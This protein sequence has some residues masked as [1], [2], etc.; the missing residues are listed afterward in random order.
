MSDK[1]TT[2]YH[3]AIQMLMANW[4]ASW[5]TF[6]SMLTANIFIAA[7]SG[8]V[9]GFYPERMV[10][11]TALGVVGLGVCLCWLLVTMRHF[12]YSKY[13]FAWARHYEREYL[14][15]E[16]RLI[17]EGQKF[18]KGEIPDVPWKD[19]EDP[20]RL[21]AISRFRVEQLMIIVICGFILLYIL[22]LFVDVLSVAG[23]G[24]VGES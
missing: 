7:L 11:K 24:C 9:I 19:T 16:V 14:S 20:P 12:D 6:S 2:G 3:T 18:S 15:P 8:V 5:S 17:S 13:W 22:M 4:T 10:I 21:R 1:V 23:T